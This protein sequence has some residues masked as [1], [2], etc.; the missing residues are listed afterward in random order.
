[1]HTEAENKPAR[2]NMYLEIHVGD[3]TVWQERERLKIHMKLLSGLCQAF[4]TDTGYLPSPL[5]ACANRT[6]FSKSA[7]NQVGKGFMWEQSEYWAFV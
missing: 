7:A 2:L 6:W 3:S 4:Q 1:M 5:S